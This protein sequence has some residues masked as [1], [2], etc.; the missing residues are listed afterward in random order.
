MRLQPQ[1]KRPPDDF[2]DRPIAKWLIFGG[3]ALFIIIVFQIPGPSS[4]TSEPAAISTPT[5]ELSPQEYS[6]MTRDEYE[7]YL[8]NESGLNERQI[9]GSL[10]NFEFNQGQLRRWYERETHWGSVDT[11]NA[12]VNRTLAD[13][14]T[15]LDEFTD[16]CLTHPQWVGKLEAARD[17]VIEFRQFD[18]ETVELNNLSDLQEHAENGLQT[19]A[20]TKKICAEQGL[21]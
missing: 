8:R 9:Q 2:L 6:R 10:D 14:V 21:G 12:Y 15:S 17:Y 20:E 7:W 13:G 5:R 1:E 19:L 11:F 4:S 3:I 16:A 18:P